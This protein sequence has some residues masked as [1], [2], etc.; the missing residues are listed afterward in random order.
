MNRYTTVAK[1]ASAE[2]V[3]DRSRFIAH[4]A[5]AFSKEEADAYIAG[6]RAQYRD[7]THNVPAFIVGEKSE[8]KWTSDDGEPQ[9]TSGPPMLQMLER[10]G[11]TNVVCVVTRYYGG[12]KLGTGGLVRAYTSSAKLALEAAGIHTVKDVTRLSVTL[13]YTLLGKLQN[14]EKSEPFTIEDIVYTE[15]V[16][17][18][19]TMDLEDEERVKALLMEVSAGT[20]VIAAEEHVIE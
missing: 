15:S 2:Q 19:L 14:L 20:A 13:P 16:T 12:I 10:E 1:E 8:L 6:I 17:L 18:A 11:L 5:R 9:G 4:I 3:I 7:A